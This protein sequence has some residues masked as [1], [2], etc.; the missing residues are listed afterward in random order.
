VASTDIVLTEKRIVGSRACSKQDLVE[1]IRLVEEGRITPV[2]TRRYGL[3]DVDQVFNA[4]RAGE[5][6]GRAV[7]VP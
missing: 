7:V 6:M 3:E 5:I 2:V 1:V 4:L